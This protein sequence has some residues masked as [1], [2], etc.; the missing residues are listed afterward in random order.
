M[1]GSFDV[2]GAS[3]SS[4]IQPATQ[5]S[6][7]LYDPES[8][9]QPFSLLPNVRCRRI[10]R[11]EGPQPSTAQ[12]EYVFDNLL[13]LNLGWPSQSGQVWPID[14]QGPYVVQ[15][16]DRLVVGGQNPDGSMFVLFDG[17]A[18]IPQTNIGPQTE[19]VTFAAS[20][21]EVRCW[22]DT[23]HTRVE[24]NAD[25][26]TDTSGFSD[27]EIH[28]RC[29]FNPADQRPGANGGIMGNAVPNAN[30]TTSQ[31]YPSGY[32]VFIDPLLFERQIQGQET[33]VSEWYISDAIRYLLVQPNPGDDYITWPDLQTVDDMLQTLAPP[34]GST[35]FNLATAVS[36]D[37][38]IRDYDATDRTLPEVL[39]DLL[40]Y[41]GFYLTWNLDLDATGTPETSLRFYRRDGAATGPI[42]AIYLDSPGTALAD[43]SLNNTTRL[44]AARDMSR[45]RNAWRVETAR[46]E[47]EISVLLAPLFTPAAGDASASSRAQFDLD[48]IVNAAPDIKRK[49][50]W[51]GA[52]ECGDGHYNMTTDQWST[53]SLDL[54]DIF[55]TTNQGSGYVVRYRPG[56]E[57]L[58]ARDSDGVPL[59][60]IL[61]VYIADNAYSSDPY[62]QVEQGAD[63]W[64]AIKYGWRLMHDR[65]GIIVDGKNPESWTTGNK[66]VPKIAGISQVALAGQ[67][68]WKPFSLRLTTVIKADK[69]ITAQAPMRD[70][71]PTQFARWRSIDAADHFRHCSISVGSI[72]YPNAGGDGTNPVVIRDDTDIATTHANQL[73]SSHEMPALAAAVTIPGVS[74]NYEVGDR[75][76]LL[77]GRDISFQTNIGASMGESP[78]YSWVVGVSWLFEGD[79]QYTELT[80]SDKRAD[81]A[82]NSW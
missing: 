3:G 11:R 72:N 50:R 14:A 60:A 40:G 71:S 68:N 5:I 74:L 70:A 51:Y 9:S 73:R 54:K 7:Y 53:Q 37:C 63:G 21:V 13:A 30:Y 10:D 31:D 47:V 6:V 79:T 2:S 32:P 42:K 61:E 49:Y 36:A 82:R 81:S 64:Q 19:M 65:L 44:H 55:P 62:V 26:P 17:F 1:A 46:K 34:E 67:E 20:G 69:R 8:V 66:A 18:A 15:T 33:L 56:S 24:R 43:G 39:A 16:D 12:F 77:E 52:D 59:K 58:I 25:D 4:L 38:M 78:V 48:N 27:W 23:I 35:V 28:D 80:L 29:R 45:V 57:T 22:D 75:I 76:N 41:A